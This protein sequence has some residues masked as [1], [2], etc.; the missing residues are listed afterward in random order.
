MVATYHDRIAILLNPN[1]QLGT[2]TVEFIRQLWAPYTAEALAQERTLLHL[3]R[4]YSPERLE[5]ACKRAL[6]YEQ[7][8]RIEIVETILSRQLDQLPLDAATDITG[9]F[10]L[11]F[12]EQCGVSNSARNPD[13]TI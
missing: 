12:T 10:L 5:A 11:N 8:I 6:Y 4:R 9:Q 3:A 7:E 1:A 2:Y 13:Q